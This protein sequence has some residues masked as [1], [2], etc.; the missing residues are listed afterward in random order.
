MKKFISIILCLC[1]LSSFSACGL[2]KSNKET[3]ITTTT[4]P[5]AEQTVAKANGLT[6]GFWVAKAD[7][8][9]DE[10]LFKKGCI[11]YDIGFVFFDAADSSFSGTVLTSDHFIWKYYINDNNYIDI[12]SFYEKTQEYELM[13]SGYFD[14]T[15]DTM[16]L[17]MTRLAKKQYYIPPDDYSSFNGSLDYDSILSDQ[18]IFSH[19]KDNEVQKNL[20]FEIWCSENYLPKIKLSTGWNTYD[21]FT[22]FEDKLAEKSGII[23]TYNFYYNDICFDE[24]DGTGEGKG[25]AFMYFSAAEGMGL[26]YE[27]TTGGVKLCVL[28]GTDFQ[29]FVPFSFDEDM[30]TLTIDKKT[31]KATEKY[32]KI[33]NFL[34]G[35]TKQEGAVKDEQ[36][37]IID[38][39][40]G[41]SVEEIETAIKQAVRLNSSKPLQKYILPYASEMVN[42]WQENEGVNDSFGMD[43]SIDSFVSEF[44][45]EYSN[46]VQGDLGLNSAGIT[47][48]PRS[49]TD[50]LEFIGEDE[51]SNI[52]SEI[53]KYYKTK[54]KS[55][56]LKN[57]LACEELVYSSNT[58]AIYD[59]DR[60]AYDYSIYPI[61]VEAENGGYF[62]FQIMYI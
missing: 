56:N 49:S 28:D 8:Q 25:N 43:P 21:D 4:A 47:V 44:E 31:Q 41:Y 55:I 61:L 1:I 17:Y 6:E 60:D 2:K 62:L 34:S 26:K 54:N 42:Y 14:E 45:Y 24:H 57:I 10:D 50:N 20:M 38:V 15:K 22:A 30:K 36:N 18:I 53:Q 33:S 13:F 46:D 19:I 39:K 3:D 59:K 48:E 35:Y 11:T 40:Q 58:K 23:E 9:T 52:I 51:S 27:I 32:Y 12:Y 37:T 5:Q 7:M 29:T 16:N